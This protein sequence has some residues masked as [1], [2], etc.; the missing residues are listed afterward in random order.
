MIIG[1]VDHIIEF[2]DTQPLREWVERYA[3]SRWENAV[4]LK[5]PDEATWFIHKDQAS[6]DSWDE[7]GAIDNNRSTMFIVMFGKSLTVVTD[8]G[9][10][11]AEEITKGLRSNSCYQGFEPSD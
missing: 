7:H 9:S 6:V 2:R 11:I 4:I 5:D 1:G 3:R 10:N 8:S